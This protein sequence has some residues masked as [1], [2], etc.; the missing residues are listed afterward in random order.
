MPLLFSYGTLRDPAVQQ[1]NFGRLLDGREDAL[2]GYRVE[3]VEITDPDVLAVSGQDHHPIVMPSGDRADQVPGTVFE[4]SDE[5]LAAAD[6]YEVDDYRR[7]LVEL[8]SGAHA[9][10]YVQAS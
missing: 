1:A 9:W 3:L 7:V 5:E 10:V 4:V 8:A 2:P 6:L